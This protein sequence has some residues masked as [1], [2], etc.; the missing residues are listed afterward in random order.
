M[1]GGPGWLAGTQMPKQDAG[2]GLIESGVVFSELFSLALIVALTGEVTALVDI[3]KVPEVA[4]A[5][6]VTL[7]ESVTEAPGVAD[8]CTTCPPTGA[9]P[10]KV[11][12]P[13]E[14][15]PFTTEAGDTVSERSVGGG[16]GKHAPSLQP[17]G[18]L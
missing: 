3:L 10:L 14:E 4:P 16:A 8:N 18:H 6:T 9:A 11:T 5:F 1:P 2:A 13:T 17:L 15:A 12:V 7:A